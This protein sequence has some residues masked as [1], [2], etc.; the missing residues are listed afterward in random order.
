M[1]RESFDKGRREQ[2]WA[3]GGQWKEATWAA[4]AAQWSK[5]ASLQSTSTG[6]VGVAAEASVPE[7]LV[8]M[9]H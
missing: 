6:G 3:V 2:S 7:P 9:G 5:E 1:L 8:Q 4:I